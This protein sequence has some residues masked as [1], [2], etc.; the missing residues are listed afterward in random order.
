MRLRSFRYCLPVALILTAYSAW[1]VEPI[2][3]ARDVYPDG[4]VGAV[5]H[6][7][8]RDR[9]SLIE[10]ARRFDLGFNEIVDANPDVDPFL[11]KPGAMVTIPAAWIPPA[12][13]G[14]PSLVVNLAELRLFLFPGDVNAGIMSFPI[15]IGEEGNE[16][17]LGTYLIIEK[18]VNPAW[19]VPASIRRQRRDLPDVVPPGPGNPLGS[20]ALRLS[21]NGILIHSTNRPWGIGRRSSHGC[22]RLYPEDM[23]LLFHRVTRGM[24][25]TIVDQPVKIGV[26]GAMVYVEIHRGPKQ[27]GAGDVLHLLAARGLLQK[28]DLGKVIRAVDEKKGYPVEVSWTIWP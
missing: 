24:R 8:V 2:H 10:I 16:T 15:G 7:M 27:V 17:P 19:R 23:K 4:F 22:L 21:S 26:R 12:S 18:S 14:R 9:E 3:A 11:P 25:V 6:Y 20:H 13:S 28:I 1:L 5:H